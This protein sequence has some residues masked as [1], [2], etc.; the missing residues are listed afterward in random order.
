MREAQVEYPNP[1]TKKKTAA[2]N[3]AR[4]GTTDGEASAEVGIYKE[5]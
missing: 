3:R 4:P 5:A 1:E 2:A